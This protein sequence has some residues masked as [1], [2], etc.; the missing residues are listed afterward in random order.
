M[1]LSAPAILRTTVMPAWPSSPRQRRRW[2]AVWY[3]CI[4]VGFF[5]L[6]LRYWILGERL[7]LVALRMIIAGGFALLSYFEWRASRA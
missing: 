4:A 3:L 5:L 6:G 7:S 2:Y 1:R